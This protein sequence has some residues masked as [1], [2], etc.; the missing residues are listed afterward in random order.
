[1]TGQPGESAK[2]FTPEFLFRV[3]F[4]LAAFEAFLILVYTLS[5]PPD[6]SNARLLGFSQPRLVVAILLLLALLLSGGLGIYARRNLAWANQL[7]K[8]LIQPSA[9]LG[10]TPEKD[11]APPGGVKSSFGWIL[12]WLSAVA[13]LFFGLGFLFAPYQFGAIE[14]YFIR[15]RPFLLYLAL[16]CGQTLAVYWLAKN[17][18]A[19]CT[20]GVA[21]TEWKRTLRVE[22]R[23]L[24]SFLFF[25]GLALFTWGIVAW[26]HLGLTPDIFWDKTGVPLL[27]WQILLAWGLGALVIAAA[28]LGR[29][30]TT[31][32]KPATPFRRSKWL[33]TGIFLLIWIVAAIA[34]NLVPQTHSHFAPGPY[35]PNYEYYPYSDAM[36]YDTAAQF[37]LIGVDL[38][39][40]DEMVDKPLYTVFL[41]LLHLVGGQR[42]QT[43]VA[44][45]TAILAVFPA[46]LYLIG[47]IMHSRAVGI[48]A[49]LLAIFKVTNTITGT[50]LIWTV[51]HPKLMMSE[52]PTGVC[53]VLLTLFLILWLHGPVRRPYFALAAGGVLGLATLIRHNVWLLLPIIPLAALLAYGRKWRRWLFSCGLF[54]LSMLL[55][56]APWMW[57]NYN[58]G[59]SPFYFLSALQGTVWENRY[60]PEIPDDSRS[61]P[62]QFGGSEGEPPSNG[63]EGTPD[64]NRPQTSTE[65]PTAP[66]SSVPGTPQAAGGIAAIFTRYQKVIYNAANNFSHNLITSVLSMPL[67]LQFDDL[68]HI[69]QAPDSLWD[70]GWTGKLSGGA[71]VLLFCNLAL[72]SLGLGLGW[73]RLKIAGLAPFLVYLGY[74]LATGLARTSGGRYIVPA[75]WVVYFYYG[76]GLVQLTWW[77][78]A[79]VWGRDMSNPRRTE[80]KAGVLSGWQ[81]APAGSDSLQRRA[82]ESTALRAWWKGGLAIVMTFFM[83]G[84]TLPLADVLFPSFY[85]NLTKTQVFQ[86][87][88]QK[89]LLDKIG[90]TSQQA[91]TFAGLANSRVTYGRAL[92][93]RF[94]DPKSDPYAREA[95]SDLPDNTP[96]LVFRLI[97]P[98]GLLTAILPLKSTPDY[99]PN[100][101]DVVVIGCKSG[102][103]VDALV[104]V[105]LHPQGTIYLS[106]AGSRLTCP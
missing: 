21:A 82:F 67:T 1:M 69:V 20:A 42:I 39:G 72:I 33:D 79:V 75:D 98:Q 65:R 43:V 27:S 93:P 66:T 62:T 68:P 53:L 35:S 41:L 95:Y 16:V 97:W 38:G 84:L 12:P 60:V 7:S 56:I 57:R 59:H 54:L 63:A 102:K 49:A 50:L 96:H 88:A 24:F 101:S 18:F 31:P 70:Y 58:M 30:F 5:L 64:K 80:G 77:G 85:Q 47:K 73:A 105:I 15:V 36:G 71:V 99:F 34:W 3:Y 74:N 25:L 22:K 91:E 83:I 13:F 40:T 100:A 6:A 17:G 103:Y 104:V 19:P 26:T 90:F 76:L 81:P 89:G 44:L 94:L 55:A 10:Q 11:F 23:V 8:K 2:K 9:R 78:M 86:L 37:G 48:V 46:L 4:G 45:Q 51:S 52:F 28:V 14:P 61:S 87:L 29:K 92:Y 32:G 106:S